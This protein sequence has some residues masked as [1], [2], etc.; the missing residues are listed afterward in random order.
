MPFSFTINISKGVSGGPAKF[1][2][3]PLTQVAPGDQIIWANNDDTKAHWPGLQNADGT[4]DQTFFMANQIAPKPKL[5]S[6]TSTTFSPGAKGT[7]TYVCS[8]EGHQDETGTIEVT[9]SQ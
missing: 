3:N 2:P 5:T 7:F 9:E 4:I 8:L 1:D 6:S